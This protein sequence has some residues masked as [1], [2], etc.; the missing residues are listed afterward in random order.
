MAYFAVVENENTSCVLIWKHICVKKNIYFHMHTAHIV[1]EIT[2]TF[3]I[4]V[5]VC[6]NICIFYFKITSETTRSDCIA[7][8]TTFNILL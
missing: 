1:F 3:C 6:V 5:C 8:G 7:Q 4:H 2:Y